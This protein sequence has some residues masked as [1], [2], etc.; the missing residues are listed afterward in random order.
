MATSIKVIPVVIPSRYDCVM[1]QKIGPKGQVVI[2]K[3]FRDELGIEP[4]DE[5]EVSLSE[6]GVLIQSV[7]TTKTL[8]GMFA[9]SG[10]LEMLVTDR[11]KESR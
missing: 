1:A 6:N 10:M 5:V 7:H 2:P 3:K 9:G 4:G 11:R 8:R